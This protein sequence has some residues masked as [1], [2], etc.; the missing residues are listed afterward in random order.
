[1]AEIEFSSCHRSFSGVWNA[2]YRI[3]KHGVLHRKMPCL[4]L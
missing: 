3:A 2:V 1:M 4:W